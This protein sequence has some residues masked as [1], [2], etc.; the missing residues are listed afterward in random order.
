MITFVITPYTVDMHEWLIENG[1]QCHEDEEFN[2]AYN[3]IGIKFHKNSKVSYYFP[4]L[5]LNYRI[6]KCVLY[7]DVVKHFIE[8]HLLGV[9]MYNFDFMPYRFNLIRS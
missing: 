4:S 6:V 7:N 1:I 3:S 2:R 9:S 5:D 8:L